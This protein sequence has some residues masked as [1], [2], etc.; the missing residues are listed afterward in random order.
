MPQFTRS[1]PRN[2]ISGNPESA[3]RD[4]S[5]LFPR[6]RLAARKRPARKDSRAQEDQVAL[7]LGGDSDSSVR[8]GKSIVTRAPLTRRAKLHRSGMNCRRFPTRL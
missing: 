7:R 8:S 1:Q 3:S 5:S 4:A 6:W 2:D